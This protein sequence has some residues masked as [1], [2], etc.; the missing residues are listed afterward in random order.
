MGYR[1]AAY[2]ELPRTGLPE[3]VQDPGGVRRLCRT[4]GRGAGH[5]GFE[6]CLVGGE[7]VAPLP[8]AG[9]AGRPIQLHACLDDTLAIAALYRSIV[10]YLIRHP[11]FRADLSP[12]SRAVAQEN[13]WR[14]QRYGIHGSFVDE[15]RRTTVSIADLVQETVSLLEEDAEALGCSDD[16]ARCLDICVRGTSS[17]DGQL[18]VWKSALGLA[19]TPHDALRAVKT[20]IADADAA[21]RRRAGQ[22]RTGCP[23]LPVPCGAAARQC[24]PAS[25]PAGVGA[26]PSA[27]AAT[28]PS[29]NSMARV[30][31]GPDGRGGTQR[32]CLPHPARARSRAPSTP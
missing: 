22:F 8:D 15:E 3:T 13:K 11:D 5:R 10:R 28:R 7:A 20:W 14:A 24:A 17:A 4:A 32:A 2:D 29:A 23:A 30:R 16:L 6:L 1:L 12:L 18:T 31:T 26:S 25:A 9:T 27:V 19:E 21:V